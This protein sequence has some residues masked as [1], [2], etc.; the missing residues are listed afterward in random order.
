MLL[1]D[2]PSVRGVV[3]CI[4]TAVTALAREFASIAGTQ[5]TDE[6]G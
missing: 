5:V 6:E 2:I 4:Q 3:V 1:Y